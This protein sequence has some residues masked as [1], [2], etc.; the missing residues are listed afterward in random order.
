MFGAAGGGG[1]DDA[2]MAQALQGTGITDERERQ[3][4]EVMDEAVTKL[5][6]TDND[7]WVRDKQTN[8]KAKQ[9]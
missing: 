9:T 3:L 7:T 1:V 8:H 6:Q 2:C 5:R 4:Q